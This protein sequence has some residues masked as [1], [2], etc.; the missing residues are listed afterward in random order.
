VVEL[1]AAQAKRLLYLEEL[2][3]LAQLKD[4][5][6]VTEEEFTEKEH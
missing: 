4:K 3:R 6:I 5:G 2:E 1:A